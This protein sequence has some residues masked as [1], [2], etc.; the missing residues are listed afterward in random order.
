MWFK[1]LHLYR[2]HDAPVVPLTTLE[3]V[4][5]EQAARPLGDNDARRL[6][7]GTPGGRNSTRFCHEVQGHRLLSAQR[8]ERL[9]PASIVREAVEERVDERERAE[10]GPLPRKEKQAIKEQVYEDLLPQAFVRSQRID[11]WWDTQRDLIGINASSAK[12]AEEVLDLLRQTL[13]SLKVTPLATK[14]LP[15]RAMTEW[16]HDPTSRPDDLALG[17]QVELQT[18]S[19][20]GVLRARRVDLD[21]EEITTLLSG[22]RQA[23]RLAIEVDER[24]SL[25]LHDDLALKSLRFADSVIEEASQSDDGD[26]AIQ[27][28]ETDFILMAQTLADTT[29]RLLDW[30]GGEATPES[31]QDTAS[32]TS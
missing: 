10:G 29:E 1:H 8:Q 15:I 6:G 19:D 27:R 9:L 16:L 12:R 14:T 30:L 17:D 31:Q 32:V 5:A 3:D 25:M 26:D 7:W 13:G 18:P 23:T 21:S 22:D 4:L 20:E 24:V 11:L 28:L 2:L